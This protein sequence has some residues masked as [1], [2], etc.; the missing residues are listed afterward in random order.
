MSTLITHNITLCPTLC[1]P[2]AQGLV[3]AIEAVTPH[4]LWA[5]HL[6]RGDIIIANRAGRLPPEP[7]MHPAA[8][9]MQLFV[10]GCQLGG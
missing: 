6:C 5:D 3:V 7:D 2:A 8:G 4:A 1:G 10:M 9:R